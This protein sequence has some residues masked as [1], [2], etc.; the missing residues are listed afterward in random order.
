MQKRL[1]LIL[2]ATLAGLLSLTACG[3]GDESDPGKSGDKRLTIYSGRSENLVKPVLEKFEKSSGID[4]DVRYGTTA[5]MAAQLLEEGE[6][7]PA[8][9]FFAQDAGALGAVTKAGQ[10]ATLPQEVL[11]RVP[12]AY[13]AGGG[14]WVG[15]SGRSRVLAYN[16]DQVPQEQLPNSVFEVTDPRWKGKIGV[17]PTNGSF[18]AFVTA[19]RVQHGDAK[20]KEFLTGLKANEPQIR[21]NN[22]QIVADI[23]AGKLAVGLVNHYYVYELA[24]ERGGTP[25]TLKARLHFFPNGD[26]GGL[27]NA[28]GVGL[29]KRA[30]SDPDARALVDYLLG[31]EAQTYFATETFEYPLA[32]GVPAAPGL[33]ELTTLEAPK[34]DLNDLDTL[35]ATVAMIKEAGLA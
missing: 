2:T 3:G 9:V 19:L 35:D 5:Q 25:E 7:S 34:I 13:R 17:A 14:Q 22:V 11:D 29:L 23:D 18:Q 26:T 16:A 27:V 32:A 21:E 30:G 6:R 1:S 15:V 28:A 20:A 10:L 24:K 8:D 4:V 33:P 31:T 12:A